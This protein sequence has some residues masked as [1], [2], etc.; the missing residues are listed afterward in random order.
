M[1]ET[2]TITIESPPEN[3]LSVQVEAGLVDRF[4]HTATD[5]GGSWR[6][7]RRKESFQ[8]ALESAVAVALAKF[9]EGLKRTEE[10]AG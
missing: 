8:D 1:A 7:K 10:G 4:V 6:S 9:L 2:R 5:K 3:T